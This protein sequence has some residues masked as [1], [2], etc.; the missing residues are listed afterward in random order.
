[1][2]YEAVEVMCSSQGK[3]GIIFLIGMQLLADLQAISEDCSFNPA[4]H[5]SFS[6]SK[7]IIPRVYDIQKEGGH[8]SKASCIILFMNAL[9]LLQRG[10]WTLTQNFW[11]YF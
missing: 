6:S 8:V 3:R 1:M 11:L 7:V 5:P 2:P 4:R 10:G 9:K